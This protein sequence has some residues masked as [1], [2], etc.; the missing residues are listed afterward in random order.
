MRQ[1]GARPLRRG[2]G[3][4]G[5]RMRKLVAHLF[6]SVDGVV[7]APDRFLR[8]DLFQDLDAFNDETVGG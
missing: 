2:E 5:V 3:G 8:A 1:Q 4:G 6:M 7:E